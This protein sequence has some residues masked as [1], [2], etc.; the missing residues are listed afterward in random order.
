M[1]KI[2]RRVL[3]FRGGKDKFISRELGVQSPEFFDFVTGY[4]ALI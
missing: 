1:I 4:K 3:K 2:F